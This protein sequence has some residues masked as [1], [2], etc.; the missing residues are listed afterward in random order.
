MVLF[1]GMV[2][3]VWN[4]FIGHRY[5]LGSLS[6]LESMGLVS[7]AYII[8]SSVRFAG[9]DECVTDME[10]PLYNEVR[11][12]QTARVQPSS[13]NQLSND[14]KEVLKRTIEEFHRKADRD[15]NAG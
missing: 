7:I 10:S 9:G 4:T 3:I 5:N 8:H 13:G 1:A 14:Q 12:E 15:F 6:L 2:W 11:N